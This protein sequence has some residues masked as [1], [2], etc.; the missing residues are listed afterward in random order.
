MSKNKL[1]CCLRLPNSKEVIKCQ[2]CKKKYH[3]ACVSTT[4]IPYNEL[5][6]EYKNSWLCPACS[7]PRSDN[8][9]TPIRNIQS[10]NS[11]APKPVDAT[12]DNGQI[13]L[14]REETD[15]LR[16]TVDS[17]SLSEV[18]SIIRHELVSILDNFK[19]NII[20]Q[21][22]SKIKIVLD[23]M[24]SINTSISFLEQKF[25]DVKLEMTN[26]I[27]KIQNLEQENKALR[28]SV[29]DLQSRLSLLEQQSR[30]CNVEIQCI[31]EFKNENLITV[32][33]Q[34]A[35]TVKCNI[36]DHDIQNCTRIM[37]LNKDSLRPRTTLVKFTTPRVR[38]TFLA[39]VLS[40][41]KKA[42]CNRDKLNTSHLGISGDIKPIYVCEHLSPAIK[43]LHAEARIKCKKIG[44]RYV[45]VKNGRVFVRKSDNSEY[46]YVKNVDLLTS[47]Q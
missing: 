39:A 37:K 14:R 43:A 24:S 44:Y 11:A 26:K 36:T 4:T 28:S 12:Q 17:E 6:S 16:D 22:D 32:V 33:K 41:N 15:T 40:F 25:E 3:F 30:A 18:R 31:P 19:A 29:T 2:N 1:E 23:N 45:W 7:R 38:D 13:S 9:T 35:S 8:T 42:A 20:E 5:T 47:L 34:I 27:E 10:Y 46:I 21:I